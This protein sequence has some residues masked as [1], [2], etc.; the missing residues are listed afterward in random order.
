[1]YRSNFEGETAHW[2]NNLTYK[3]MCQATRLAGI[4]VISKLRV[5]KK[6]VS[7]SHWDMV[8]PDDQDKLRKV[9]I[10]ECKGELT[11]SSKR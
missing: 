8:H 6:I 10:M 5:D 1:M 2:W 9:Y 3:G 7:A 4:G 11:L